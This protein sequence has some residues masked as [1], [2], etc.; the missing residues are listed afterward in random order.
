MSAPQDPKI[1][2]DSD[3]KSRVESEKEAIRQKEHEQQ[4]DAPPTGMPP[5]SFPMLVSTIVTQA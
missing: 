2:V 3:W 5:A 1:I 4:H